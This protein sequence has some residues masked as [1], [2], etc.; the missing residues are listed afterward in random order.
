MKQGYIVKKEPGMYCD[1]DEWIE[2]ITSTVYV[3]HTGYVLKR[4]NEGR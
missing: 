2:P 1:V 4:K 3:H